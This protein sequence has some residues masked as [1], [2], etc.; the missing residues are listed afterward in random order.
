ML[1]LVAIGQA[2]TGQPGRPVTIP[3]SADGVQRV[4]I[5]VGS[6]S[7]S[8]NHLVVDVGKP[9]ELILVSVATIV[10]HNFLIS[11]PAGGLLVEQDVGPGKTVTVRFTPS[12]PGL[13]P[14]IC[15]KRLWPLPSHRDKGME[16][17]LEVKPE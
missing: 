3:V 12:Q 7:Y 10:P 6:Y 14:F 1:C 11:D 2:A 9:V 8:P 4:T 17:V 13:F 15:D 5:T 16:G